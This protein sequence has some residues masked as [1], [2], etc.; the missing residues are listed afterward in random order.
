MGRILELELHEIANGDR[1]RFGDPRGIGL[2]RGLPVMEPFAAKDIVQAAL[3]ERLLLNAAGNNTLRFV[4][5]LIIS[6]DDLR[7]GIRRLRRAI[8]ASR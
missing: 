3:A 1:E 4:P 8:A 2:M 7:E 6:E 5:P